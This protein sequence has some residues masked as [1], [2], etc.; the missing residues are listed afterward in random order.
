MSILII[1]AHPDDEV[2]GCG[3]TISKFVSQ[4]IDVYVAILGQGVAS[5]SDDSGSSSKKD[6]D[7]L[8][9]QSHEVS[10]FLGVTAISMFNLP[11]NRFDSLALLDIVKPIEKMISK[12]KPTTIFTHHA[13]DL[14]ID[15]QVTY[16]AV[17][18]AT[19][20]MSD[21]PVKE[22]FSFEIPS[23]TEWAFGMDPSFIPNYFIDISDHINQKTSAMEKYTSEIQPFPHPRSNRLIKNL[24]QVRGAAVGKNYCEAFILIRK[25][26]D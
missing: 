13:G 3:G 11:D 12:I 17:I 24:A 20:P 26:M 25:I 6:I 2:L 10:K 22:I 8:H 1:A 15:H 16:R 14:N 23:S 4:N 21:C 9:Q 18:T 19:R 7:V 5:R